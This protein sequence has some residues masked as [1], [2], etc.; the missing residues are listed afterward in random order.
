[1]EYLVPGEH[2]G[3]PEAKHGELPILVHCDTG[4][5]EGHGTNLIGGQKTDQ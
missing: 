1:M 5:A 4:Y 3:G 2:Q